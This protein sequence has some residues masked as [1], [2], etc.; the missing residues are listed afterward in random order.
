MLDWTLTDPMKIVFIGVSS[1][2]MV[3]ALILFNRIFGLR[4]FSKLSG[5]DF[6]ITVA[7]GSI[8]G[9]T[10]IAEDPPVAQGAI[11]LLSLFAVQALIATG[12]VRLDWFS[13]ILTNQPRLVWHDGEFIEA[14]MRKA[15]ITRCDI[16]AKMREANAIQLDDVIAVVVETTGDISVLHKTGTDKTLDPVV[17]E[18]V[19]GWTGPE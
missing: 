11:A 4:S 13:S 14:Q 1:I 7:F 5:F 15:Q 12:R 10:V 19:T 9:A 2:G 6:A 3:L 16:I 18:G 17:M 8:L